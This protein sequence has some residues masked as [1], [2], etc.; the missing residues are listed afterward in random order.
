MIDTGSIKQRVENFVKSHGG[1]EVQ[2]LSLDGRHWYYPDG[3]YRST[4]PLGVLQDVAERR[5]FSSDSEHSY[6]LVTRRKKY[7][8]TKAKRA[9]SAFNHFKASLVGVDYGPEQLETL[10]QL[11]KEVE[12]ADGPFQ[13]VKKELSEHPISRQRQAM[14]DE[15]IASNQ[16]IEQKTKELNNIQI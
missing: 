10:Q 4:D 15:R 2:V 12:K 13:A 6:E 8:E 9:I 7:H 3:A 11:K 1:K 14:I 5:Y 16:R